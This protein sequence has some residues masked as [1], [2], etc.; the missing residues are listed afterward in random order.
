MPE[1]IQISAVIPTYNRCHIIGRAIE[2]VLAQEYPPA[3]I[4]VI[5]D[6]SVDSTREILESYGEKVRW[7]RQANAGV[8][9]AR[10]RG[11][12]ET[13]CAWIAF[14]DADDYWLPDHLGRIVRAI[15]ATGGEAAL[16]FSDLKVPKEEGGSQYWSLCGFGIEG[17]WEF[18]RDA[19]DWA[20][21]RIQPMMVQA[22]VISRKVFVELGGFS[23]QLRTR[24]DTL[25]FFKLSLLYPACAVSGCGTI[26]NSDDNLRLTQVYNRYSLV[27]MQAT[28][29]IY[30]ELISSIKNI[31]HMRR[32]FLRDALATSYFGAGRVFLHQ[33]TYLV[34]TKNFLISCLVSP[35]VFAK[36]FHGSMVRYFINK[37]R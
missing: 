19:G 28:V 20:F 13:K 16:Y 7:V 27:Y 18:R 34:A 15:N 3:E 11:V 10:N 17:K 1:N 30:K 5:D 4:I 2:S 25:L 12:K 37:S 9:A 24:E 35:L 14:L 29:F 6:G 26:M 21:L 23:E 36:E 33:R 22:S 32:Q 31:N 8:S